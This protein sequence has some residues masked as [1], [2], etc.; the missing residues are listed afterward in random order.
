MLL[1]NTIN[2]RLP[3]SVFGHMIIR[4]FGTIICAFVAI[5][6]GSR[7]FL[8]SSSQ[9]GLKISLV[10]SY[11]VGKTSI[12]R[13]L[14]D[15]ESTTR[16][17]DVALTPSVAQLSRMVGGEKVLVNVWDTAGQERFKSLSNLYLRG[18]DIVFAVI[19]L[20]RTVSTYI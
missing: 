8:S 10:G 3:L 9:S 2:T 1:N 17:K 13:R 4:A 16:A 15:P 12:I 6:S 19:D 18:S 11:A 5:T 7:R 14:L 20:E